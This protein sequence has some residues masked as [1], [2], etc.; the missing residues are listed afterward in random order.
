MRLLVTVVDFLPCLLQLQMHVKRLFPVSAALLGLVLLP[1]CHAA[2][3]ATGP[4]NTASGNSQTGTASLASATPSSTPY[5]VSTEEITT[6]LLVPESSRGRPLSLT[7]LIP[8]TITTLDTIYL[9]STSTTS[10]SSST[11]STTPTSSPT[12]TIPPVPHLATHVDATF[13]VLGVLLILTGLPSAFWGHKNRWSS[14]FLLGFY[15]LAIAVA[16]I[17]LKLGVEERE[18]QQLSLPSSKLRGLYLFACIVAGFC[19][20]AIAIFFWQATKYMIGA[21]G[22]F[23]FAMWIQAMRHSGLVRPI[24]FRWLMYIG[25]EFRPLSFSSPL[26]W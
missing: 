1:S 17:I 6:T 3:T 14:F 10:T 5:T 19:G 25:A 12:P 24:G 11:T 7:A 22:G 8:T 23:V 16:A 18:E 13:A 9:T 26:N 4:T 15:T 21:M 20:G 2:P